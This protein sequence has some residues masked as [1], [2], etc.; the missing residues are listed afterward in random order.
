MLLTIIGI[1]V[2]YIIGSIPT[3]YI[4][5]RVLKGIDIRKFGSGNIGATNAFRVLGKGAGITVLVLDAFKGFAAVVFLG[6]YLV[7][8]NARSG[9]DLLWIV[10]AFSC[11]AGHVWTIFLGFKGGKGMATTLGVLIGLTLKIP[12]LKTVLGIAF[13]IWLVFFIASRIVSLASLASALA[14]P[15]LAIIF[16]QSNAMIALSIVLS[17]LVIFRHKANIQRLLQGKEPRLL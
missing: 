16:K 3:A 12:G 13:L 17:A 2:R 11:V 8:G 5:G 7:S 14:L 10:L 4:F 15:V 9:G 6:G 1:F